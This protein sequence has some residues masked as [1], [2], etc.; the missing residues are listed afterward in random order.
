LRQVA[1]RFAYATLAVFVVLVATGSP[2][3]TH[4]DLW[5]DVT[6][7]LTLALVA[8]VAVLLVRHVWR[9]T[10]HVFERLIFLV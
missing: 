6:F 9:P 4:F 10:L 3:A 5:S 8:A 7:E 1:R 2:M